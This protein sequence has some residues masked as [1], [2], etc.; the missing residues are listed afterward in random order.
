MDV[1]IWEEE[2]PFGSKDFLFFFMSDTSEKKKKK[3]NTT[4]E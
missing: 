3:R 2:M 4:V 1:G